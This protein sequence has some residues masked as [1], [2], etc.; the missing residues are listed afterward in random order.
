MS[1]LIMIDTADLVPWGKN[2]RVNDHAVDAVIASIEQFGFASP[3]VAMSSNKMVICGHTRLKAAQKLNL[4]QIPCHLIDVDEKTAERLAIAD[5]QV[6]GLSTFDDVKLA[7]ILATFDDDDLDG[8][9]FSDDEINDLLDLVEEESIEESNCKPDPI[10]TDVDFKLMKGDCIESMKKIPENSIDAIFTDPPYHLTSIT[11]R[12]GKEGSAD[13]QFG[14]DGAFK[15]ASR[16]FM[17]QSWDGGD[18]AFSAAFWDQCFRVLKPGGFVLAFSSTRTVFKMGVAMMDSGLIVRDTVHWSYKTGFPKGLDLST[19]IDKH[20]GVYDQRKVI[21]RKKQ[22]GSKFKLTEMLIDNGGFNDPDRETYIE[23][24]PA[25]EEAKSAAGLNIA[26]KPAV[27]PA[28]LARKP[29][30]GSNAENYLKHGTG[31]LNIDACRYPYDD[32]DSGWIGSNS[33]DIS[34]GAGK[35]GYGSDC[36]GDKQGSVH[37]LGRYPANIFMCA[38]PSRAERDAGLKHLK[39]TKGFDAVK[40]TEGSAGLENPR[41]GSGRTADTILNHHPTVKPLKLTRWCLNLIVPKGGTVLDPFM[42]SGTTAAAAIL[43]GFNVIGCEMTE[44]YFA[45]IEGR[46]EHAKRVREGIVDEWC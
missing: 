15:R 14:T 45:L 31:A 24:A 30:E 9:G 32:P 7:D 35:I 11:E 21:K 36:A 23:T 28:V 44:E 29:I 3:V 40:R 38:K 12:F 33:K 41:A 22:K 27:E 37:P 4:K 42:G 46:V 16:G 10:N 19:A 34:I 6:G 20:L 39:P 17:G 13:A 5:N 25:S 43:E 2:P 26:L 1:Q 18:I 8:L